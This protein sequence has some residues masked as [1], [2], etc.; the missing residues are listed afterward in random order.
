MKRTR[1]ARQQVT[2]N[3]MGPE[4][5]RP[6]WRLEEAKW[7]TGNM[8]KGSCT[9]CRMLRYS[10][11][12]MKSW[13]RE[14]GSPWGDQRQSVPTSRRAIVE[15]LRSDAEA[16]RRQSEAIRSDRRA[17]PQ[18]R[19]LA[20]STV[21]RATARAGPSAKMRVMATRFHA[22]SSSCR[23]RG[24]GPRE[25]EEGARPREGEEGRAKGG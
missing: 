1:P 24:E 8:A 4:A 18:R 13:R 11:M 25:G 12:L 5:K 2:A 20:F 19:T 7:R 15:H 3:R 23:P 10:L 16:I 9:L 21:E 14:A 6:R 17:S 22:A